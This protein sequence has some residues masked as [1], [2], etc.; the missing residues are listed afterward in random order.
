M[1][2]S[3]AQKIPLCSGPI[4]RQAAMGLAETTGHTVFLNCPTLYPGNF[5]DLQKRMYGRV[6]AKDFTGHQIGN[7]IVFGLQ[8]MAYEN[9]KAHRDEVIERSIWVARCSLCGAFQVYKYKTLK[10]MIGM[11]LADA[12][13][14]RCLH[15]WS[16]V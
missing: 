6:W 1:M 4:N 8:K 13:C 11:E 15:G 10:K 7:L 3:P 14:H 12:K 2:I 16:A 9:P 5:K